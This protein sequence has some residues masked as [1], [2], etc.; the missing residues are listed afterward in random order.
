VLAAL[1]LP[2]ARARSAVRIGLGRGTRPDDVERAAARITAEV[3]RL[4]A[5]KAALGLDR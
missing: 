4:R 2:A 3:R 1:G 5:E